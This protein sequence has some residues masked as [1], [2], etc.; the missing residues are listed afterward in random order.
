MKLKN[1]AKAISFIL[2]LTVIFSFTGCFGGKK[3]ALVISGTNIDSEI[4]DYYL[5]KVTAKPN[6]YGLNQN[7]PKDEAREAAIKQCIRYLAINTDFHE[8]GLSLTSAEKVVVAD[9]VNNYQIRFGSHY[10]KIGV[11]RETLTKIFTCEAYESAIF[12]SVYDK[13]VNDKKAEAEIKSYFNLNYIAFQN[14]CA[15]FTGSD[16]SKISPVEKE[17]IINSFRKISSASGTDSGKFAQECTNAGYTASEVIIIKKNS[18]G[19]PEGFFEKVSAQAKSTV[20]TYVYDECVFNIRAESLEELGEGVYA[21]YR[22]A[23]IKD[24]YKANWEQYVADYCEKFTLEEAK[25]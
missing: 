13:G 14:I 20:S 2:I 8:R 18:D 4:Y 21:N 7:P 11:S 6:D 22:S 16:G 9:N 12:N 1:F 24:M 17:A 3:T 25:I 15:Y 23:C 10:K 5:D 19:Y